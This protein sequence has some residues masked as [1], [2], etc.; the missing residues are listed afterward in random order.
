[1]KELTDRERIK[2]LEG[3]VGNLVDIINEAI[4]NMTDSDMYETKESLRDQLS[5]IEESIPR[6]LP[7]LIDVPSASNPTFGAALWRG[8]RDRL[9]W[10]G[11]S[12]VNSPFPY[13]KSN[14]SRWYYWVIGY[15]TAH[16]AISK[17]GDAGRDELERRYKLNK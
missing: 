10:R 1:V 16:S 6:P 2:V 4:D 17:F 5:R 15:N 8:V 9:D 3:V 14:T 11:G 13:A 12:V 7:D